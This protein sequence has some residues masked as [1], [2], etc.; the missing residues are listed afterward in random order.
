M[1]VLAPPPPGAYATFRN[2]DTAAQVVQAR[3]QM[4]KTILVASAA[5]FF[6]AVMSLGSTLNRV[7]GNSDHVAALDAD[8]LGL[9]PSTSAAAPPPSSP[10]AVGQDSLGEASIVPVKAVVFSPGGSPDNPQ[11]AGKSI[12]GDPATAWSTDRY[13]DADPFPKFKPGLGLLL[14]LP[15]P[16]VLSSLTIDLKS[17]GTFAEIRGAAD[18]SPKALA[19][20]T[21]LSARTLLQPGP[22][23]IE[24]STRTPVS[25]VLVSISTLGATDGNNRTEISEITL[26]TT[27]RA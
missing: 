17:T 16:T 11:D 13:Y 10:D 14:Q 1:P 3:R 25:T 24:L 22:N 6:V 18:E 9:S 8:Q 19:D 23:R 27:A 21:E 26:S 12:D 4:M 5:I 7:L 20:T 2:V 15:Q